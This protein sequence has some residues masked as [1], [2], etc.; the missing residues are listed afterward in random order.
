MATMSQIMNK[1]AEDVAAI[2]NLGGGGGTSTNTGS[3]GSTGST[4]ESTYHAAVP[5]QD[6]SPVPA[7]GGTTTGS[8]S[9]PPPPSGIAFGSANSGPV[10]AGGGSSTG[11]ASSPPPPSGTA[12]FGS[13]A[14]GFVTSNALAVIKFKVKPQAG[15]GDYSV[16]VSKIGIADAQGL[17][18][19]VTQ[20][21]GSTVTV[22][23]QKMGDLDGNGVIDYRDLA[24]FGGAYGTS[25][26]QA[27]Y[28]SKADLNDDGLVNYL[29]LA[30]FGA[31]YGK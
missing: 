27:A 5:V 28:N 20:I 14:T 12:Y 3:T 31:N 22:G 18:I 10:P 25:R 26:Q 6:A 29:D 21:R 24:I 11:S 8:T 30:I 4:T 23:G 13:P 17:D 15:S 1:M 16:S 9:S 2:A 19:P 7:T